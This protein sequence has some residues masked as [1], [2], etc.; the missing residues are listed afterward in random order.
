MSTQLLNDH[1]T[2]Y[3]NLGVP[4]NTTNATAQQTNKIVGDVDVDYKITNNGKLRITAFNHSNE[5]QLVPLSSAYTQGVGLVYK[6]EFNTFGE[7]WKRYWHAILGEV[8]RKK[9]KS[10][11]INK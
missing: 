9:K 11:T 10:V 1:L 6:E 2:I 5:D 7:L 8:D 4:T 3:G